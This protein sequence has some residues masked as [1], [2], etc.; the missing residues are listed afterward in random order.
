[1]KN[2]LGLI[3]VGVFALLAWLSTGLYTVHQTEL[4]LVIQFGNPRAAVTEPGLHMKMPWPIQNVHKLDKRVLNLDLPEEEVIAQDL[5]RLVV[6]AYARFQ[7]TDPLRF[8]QTLTDTNIARTRLQ[9]ILGSNVRRILGSQTFAAV[10]S[11]QRAELM[12][13]IRDGMN[14]ETANFGINVLDVR[15]RRADL[16]AENSAAIYSR[17]QQERVREAAEFRAQ[18]EQ[19]SQE[20]RSRADRDVTVL[21]AEATRQS[22]IV[23]GEGDAQKNRIFAE[24]FGADPDFFAFYR[25][26]RAYEG[27]LGGDNTTIV[28]SPDSDFFRYFDNAQ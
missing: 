12:R 19:I 24:A 10:L 4:A 8:Y 6:D 22:E 21:R 5:K 1:M 13:A 25:S 11:G 28:L 2:Y 7:I 3:A 16:P 27:A 14:A 26:M 15:I 23:R 20:I 18:G 17:M 9:P